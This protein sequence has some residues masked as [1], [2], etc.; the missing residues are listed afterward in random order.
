[1]RFLMAALL[2]GASFA[3]Q[4]GTFSAKVIVVLDGDTVMVLRECGDIPCVHRNPLRIRLADID[5]PEKDQPGG[6]EASEALAAMV[7]KKSVRVRVSDIDKYGRQVAFVRAGEVDVN[8]RMLRLGM[9]WEYSWHHRNRAYTALQDEA[10]RARLGLWRETDPMPPWKWRKLHP[11]FHRWTLFARLAF[12][13]E[14]RSPADQRF[15]HRQ[16]GIGVL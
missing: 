16:L 11:A 8:R 5:A 4:G 12:G 9:A 15:Y 6:Q 1:M 14:G 3:A 13:N 7:L 2:A 10:R